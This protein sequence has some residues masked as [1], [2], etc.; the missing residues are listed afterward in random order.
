LHACFACSNCL[1]VSFSESYF[2]DLSKHLDK[3]TETRD[4]T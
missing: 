3:R 1:L 4:Q 2:L